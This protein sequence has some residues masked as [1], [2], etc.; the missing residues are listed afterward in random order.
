MNKRMGLFVAEFLKNNK[1]LEVLTDTGWSDFAGLS[2]KPVSNLIEIKTTTT[3]LK[4]TQEHKIFTSLL[5]PIKSF[6]FNTGDKIKSK[7]GEEQVVSVEISNPEIVFDLVEVEK[8]NRFYA[9]NLLV[10]NCQFI[11]FDETLIN[12]FVLNQLHGIEPIDKQGTVRFYKKPTKGNVYLLSLDPSIGTG[13]DPAAIQVFEASTMQQIAEW[14]HNKT[15]I[16]AQVKL[17]K[18]LTTYLADETGNN[19]NVYWSIENN[20]LGEAAL[21]AIRNIGEENIP[22]IFLS[23]PVKVGQTRKFRKGFNTTNTNKLT[24]CSKLKNLIE[25]KKM[26]I[27]SRKLISELKTFVSVENTYRAKPGE[28]DD[29]VTSLLTLIRMFEA[30]KNYIPSLAEVQD[31]SEATIPLPFT[32]S[33]SSNSYY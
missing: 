24:A 20:T 7:N 1:G 22:G 3:S 8:N 25:H 23:E 5:Q 27:Y 13:G 26:Q 28:T 10:A 2:I 11:S 6:T 15:P 17:V 33:T 9:N 14:T 18:E 30:I 16:E 19:N 29:L 31:I 4:C 12:P 21:V 32:M